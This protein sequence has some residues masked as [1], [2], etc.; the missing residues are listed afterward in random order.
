MRYD[1]L[2]SA[3][4]HF[5]GDIPWQIPHHDL[6]SGRVLW[7]VLEGWVTTTVATLALATTLATSWLLRLGVDANVEWTTLEVDRVQVADHG[8]CLV[9]GAHLDDSPSTRTD[10]IGSDRSEK[11]RCRVS[12]GRNRSD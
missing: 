9:S 8:A 12:F 11:S 7:A 1:L 5:G 3:A 10:E 2:E 4:K 6:K